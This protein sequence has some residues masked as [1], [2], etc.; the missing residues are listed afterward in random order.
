MAIRAMDVSAFIVT[1]NNDYFLHSPFAA[2]HHL[3]FVTGFPLKA[4]KVSDVH[5]LWNLAESCDTFSDFPEEINSATGALMYENDRPMVVIC[6]G[7]ARI[8]PPYSNKCYAS[9]RQN[10]TASWRQVVT[11]TEARW[12]AASVVI[13]MEGIGETFWVTGGT[14]GKSDLSSTEFVRPA[15]SNRTRPGPDLPVKVRSHCLVKLD[16]S[17]VMVIGG[18]EQQGRTNSKGT[19]IHNFDTGLWTS[20]PYLNIG[21]RYH[22]CGLIT[23]PVADTQVVIVTGGWDGYE[24]WT[25]S[26]EMWA[27]D[28]DIWIDGPNLPQPIA[29]ASSYTRSS[30]LT[31]VG[32]FAGYW[33]TLSKSLLT[34]RCYNSTCNWHK[35]HEELNQRPRARA[36][37]VLIPT[38]LSS[39]CIR[40]EPIQ[41]IQN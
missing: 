41:N 16:D 5:F 12:G 13:D 1:F 37:A 39:D 4:S 25:G 10:V 29:M 2:Y 17:R 23:D 21:R 36:V 32:G 24:S 15:L 11:M 20:G 27:V 31:L 38:S 35:N 30:E 9:D 18:I 19:W 34:I 28:S 22:S 8:Y 6:S 3:L 40:E 33:S 26:T 7:G 14:N